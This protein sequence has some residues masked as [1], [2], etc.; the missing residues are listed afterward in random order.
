MMLIRAAAR[1]YAYVRHYATFSIMLT[2]YYRMK[3]DMTITDIARRFFARLRL[4][5][6]YR[7]AAHLPA[8]PCL[9]PARPPSRLIYAD[10]LRYVC[11]C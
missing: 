5:R 9:P 6:H 10:T 4:Y 2:R 1:R 8:S 3:I 11:R 7:L